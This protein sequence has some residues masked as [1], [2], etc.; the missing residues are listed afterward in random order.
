MAVTFKEVKEC[1]VGTVVDQKELQSDLDTLVEECKSEEASKLN[2]EG[3]D[4]QLTYLIQ[5]LGPG[6][7]LARLDIPSDEIDKVI[8]A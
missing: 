5:Q 7:L 8:G 1:L 3:M 2:N 4:P 6:E